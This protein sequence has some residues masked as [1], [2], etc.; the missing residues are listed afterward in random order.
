MISFSLVGSSFYRKVFH[1]FIFR[2]IIAK[3]IKRKLEND[4][5]S[6]WSP[7]QILEIKLQNI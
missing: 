5:K 3:I 1:S 6:P 4:G 7:I 2:Q